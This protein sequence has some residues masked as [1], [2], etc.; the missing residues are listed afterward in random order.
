MTQQEQRPPPPNRQYSSDTALEKPSRHHGQTVSNPQFGRANSDQDPRLPGAQRPRQSSVPPRDYPPQGG[1]RGE[2]TQQQRPS[3]GQGSGFVP[4]RQTPPAHPDNFTPHNAA[5]AYLDR[6]QHD[7]RLQ[8]M[9]AGAP[10]RSFPMTSTNLGP[11]PH[12]S[13]TQQSQSRRPSSTINPMDKP[14]PLPQET[15]HRRYV[16]DGGH[17]Q[18]AGS[19]GGS[20]RRT[21]IRSGRHYGLH[22]REHRKGQ[23][24]LSQ[25]DR[26]PTFPRQP[27]ES[28]LDHA[29]P[30]FS[31][32]DQSY[33]IPVGYVDPRHVPLP[34]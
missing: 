12:G 8:G 11:T 1:Y 22:N 13:G 19:H 14:L 9:L 28:I 16:S 23:P 30:V 15:Q 18:F 4:L 3:P 34:E 31:P 32:D 26:Y 6:V 2:P 25:P 27:A 20:G 21:S 5:D 17:S 7:P 29:V 33:R 24:S 10:A